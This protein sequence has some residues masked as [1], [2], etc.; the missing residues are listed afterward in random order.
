MHHASGSVR[1]GCASA[2]AG[3]EA[4]VDKDAMRRIFLAIEVNLVLWILVV[5]T[6][7]G[8]AM[9]VLGLV[10]AAIIQHWAYYGLYRASRR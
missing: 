9:A 5:I 1:N 3:E 6:T 8:S 7:R 10:L 4:L 2:S